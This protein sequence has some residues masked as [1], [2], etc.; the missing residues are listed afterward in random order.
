MDRKEPLVSIITVVFNAAATIER[1]IQSVLS[2]SY[3]NIEYI[4]IDGGS[5]DGTLDVIDKY[6]DRF[7]YF[8]SEPD[9]G[10][11][12]AMNK[13]I[14]KATGDI[15]GL[16]NADDWYEPGA[17]QS[18]ADAFTGDDVDIVYGGI[19]L[20]DSRGE[21]RMHKRGDLEKCFTGMPIPHPATFVCKKAYEKYGLF[22]TSYRIA[23][24]H[25]LVL[26]MYVQGARFK[27]MNAVTTNFSLSGISSTN[28]MQA[29]LEDQEI[30]LKYK[31]ICPYKVKAELEIRNKIAYAKCLTIMEQKPSIVVK[32]LYNLLRRNSFVI[33]GTGIWG[34]RIYDISKTGSMN[35]PFFVDSDSNKQGSLFMGRAVKRPESLQSYSGTVFV[36][37]SGHDAEIAEKLESIGNQKLCWILLQ[38]FIA[39]ISSLYDTFDVRDVR[40]TTEE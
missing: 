15:I 24:D 37:V 39:E 27:A 17:I 35:V 13:G 16:L 5:T 33:W 14:R 12:D 20:V 30:F 31:D 9:G 21:K 38:D 1:T 32:V 28:H 29:A 26:R 40:A 22:D 2:Q 4:I 7:A 36:A 3:G 34:K 19:F 25:D 11:Y 23:G 18:V 6:R 10:I 8:V